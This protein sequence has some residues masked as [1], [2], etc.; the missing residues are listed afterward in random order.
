V[1]VSGGDEDTEIT[2]IRNRNCDDDDDDDDPTPSQPDLTIDKIADRTEVLAGS[3]ASYTIT[4]RNTGNRDIKNATLS[5][6][7]PES[8][9][10][11]TDPGGGINQG[12]T[13]QWDLGTLR[14]NSTTVVR[15]RVRVKDSV[16]QGSSIRNTA[17]VRGEGLTRSDTHTIVVP[18]PPVTGLGGF[19][20]GIGSTAKYL[21]PSVAASPVS[22]PISDPALPMTIWLTTIFIGLG[23]GGTFGR[24]FLF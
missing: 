2:R 11:I 24:K 4:I 1:A 21:T 12:G 10:T 16:P 18:R 15:Y 9:M 7:Y 6:D 14:A 19:I 13:L 17:T 20:K 22:G 5:D 8:M 3:V 23:F